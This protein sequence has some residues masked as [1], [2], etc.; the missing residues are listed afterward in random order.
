M[1]PMRSAAKHSTISRP[2]AEA[3]VIRRDRALVRDL[4]DWLAV[5]HP[6]W[7]TDATWRASFGGTYLGTSCETIVRAAFRRGTR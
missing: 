3:M 7:P 5:E 2:L 1:S 4:V 6:G